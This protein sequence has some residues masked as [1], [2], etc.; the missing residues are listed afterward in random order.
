MS[1]KHPTPKAEAPEPVLPRVRSHAEVAA[2]DADA[3]GRLV[4]EIRARICETV[5][6]RGGHLASSLG[7]VELTVALH[8]VFDFARDR[9]VLDVGHQ[10]YAHKL[11]TGRADAFGT[12]RTRGGLS[13]F[14]NPAESPADPFVVGHASTAISTA[15]GLAL[16]DKLAGRERRV[17]AVI[18]DGALTGGLSFEALNHAGD[19]GVNLLVVLNDNEMAISRTV[20]ALAG[21]LSRV[22]AEPLYR[23]LKSETAHLLEKLP[24]VGHALE[25]AGERTLEL[26][27][28]AL[29]PGGLFT[30][31]GFRYYGPMNGHDVPALEAQL[32]RLAK[33][34][35]PL[36]LHVV[37]EK[38]RGHADARAD[39][40]RF[41]GVSPRA[42][43]PD[44]GP[45]AGPAP[46]PRLADASEIEIPEA[47]DGPARPTYSEVF[48]D[49]ALAAAR[50]DERVVALTAAMPIGT[51]LDR[52]ERELPK[53]FFDVGICEPH[54]V[55]LAGALA[56][57]GLRPIVALYSTFLQ[58]A[59][60][61]VFHDVC[62]QPASPVVL[63]IDR[64][65]LVAA[66][67]PT[68]HGAFDI[69]LLRPIPRLVLMAPRDG[70]S[71]GR[72]LDLALSLDVPSAIRYPRDRTAGPIQ[73]AEPRELA[74][75]TGEVLRRGK[76][77]TIFAYG[78]CVAEA[79]EAAE[80]LEAEGVS[81][82]VADAR[83]AK[84]LDAELVK[85]LVASHRLVL[86]AEDGALAGGFGAAVL[87]C[88]AG[89][90]LDARR[91]RCVGLPDRF[92]EHA[93][94]RELVAEFGLDAAGLARR[95]L[96]EIA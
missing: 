42:E 58:R 3:L 64:A 90:G 4:G 2:L 76:K 69:S 48:G 13:G 20:G 30:D 67:G 57:S 70:G 40:A 43:A 87:E 89:Q 85:E 44:A 47:V 74:V 88:A 73:A 23:G 9:L 36:L 5:L 71:L 82:A 56:S 11:L 61:Q 60:D 45:E 96:E 17:V 78:A 62:L 59:V 7:A 79:M 50:R 31:L 14:P 68:H 33:A 93:T 24:L 27:R 84:P 80:L 22:R 63:A 94:R 77:A 35:G 55:A 26:A 95:V 72:M 91:I 51:C 38:G 16:A 18:G 41:H 15:L 53:R 19:L 54:A 39:P 1:E 6:E 83:F 32:A 52:F 66:D 12:L 21:Y 28:R 92:A 81:V 34:E 37:T 46:A 10:C 86:T 8:R 75:G 25:R 29:L 49:H 65:G